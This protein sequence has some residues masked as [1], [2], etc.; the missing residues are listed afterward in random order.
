M[1]T[2]RSVSG[3]PGSRRHRAF[4]VATC[5]ALVL[6]AVGDAG[7]EIVDS[8]SI[9]AGYDGPGP[10]IYLGC[11]LLV[12]T[13]RWRFVPLVAVVMSAF[14]L[15]GGMAD[16]EFARRLVT[17]AESIAFGAAWL[18]MLAFAAVIVF[19]IAAVW[20]KPRAESPTG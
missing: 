8:R 4:L 12:A 16:P 2:Q 10:L 13:V 9:V 3:P 18:Q 7:P 15:F 14:F 5:A 11:A 17:P 1:K 19:A 6:A 20:S